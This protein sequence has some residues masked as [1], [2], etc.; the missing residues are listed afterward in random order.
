IRRAYDGRRRA[1]VG[2]EKSQSSALVASDL[3][4]VVHDASTRQC[5][6]QQAKPTALIGEQRFGSANLSVEYNQ[7]VTVDRRHRDRP[8][9][10]RE[11]QWERITRLHDYRGPARTAD[12]YR[13]RCA[14]K[15]DVAA[16]ACNDLVDRRDR[17]AVRGR[18]AGAKEDV[19]PGGRRAH[20]EDDY[21]DDC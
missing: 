17:R 12:Q 7:P 20:G 9:M 6:I 21:G 11:R 15:D 18:I 13:A 14:A 4:A 16:V 2:V 10:A 5:R 3:T 8:E 19:E 1:A